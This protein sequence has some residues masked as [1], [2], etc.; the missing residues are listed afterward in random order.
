MAEYLYERS[1]E[2]RISPDN[3]V[4]QLLQIGADFDIEDLSTRADALRALVA[5]K[6]AYEG[7]LRARL[8][9][10]STVPHFSGLDGVWDIRPVFH[11]ERGDIIAR[12][13]ALLLNVSWH[14]MDGTTH[15]AIVQ[16]SEEDWEDFKEEVN[17]LETRR[18]ALRSLMDTLEP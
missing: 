17:E 11:R 2:Y 14:D 6:D 4:A 5:S 18:A 10:T 8:Q 16:L 9:A 13:A 15:E 1:R 12:V 7:G 3:A